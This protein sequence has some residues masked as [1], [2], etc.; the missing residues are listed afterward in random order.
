[1]LL[2]RALNRGYGMSRFR[3]PIQ[4]GLLNSDCLWVMDEVQL[5][6]SGLATTAQLQAFRKALGTASPVHSLW[7]SATL[8][9]DWLNTVDFAPFGATL[10]SFSLSDEDRKCP[11]IQARISCVKRL[12]KAGCTSEKPNEVVELI[13]DNHQ[14]GTRT[15]VVVNTVKRAMEIYQALK[16]KKPKAD[17]SLLHSRFRP[18]DRQ[19]ALEKVLR[20]PGPEG[21]ICVSTQVVEAGVDF[22]AAT[23]ITELAPWASLVQRFGRCNRYGTDKDA[24]VL[25]LDLSLGKKG[26]ALP[27][28]PEELSQ[29]A[30]QLVQLK[31]VCPAKLPT[32]PMKAGYSHV[33]R[34]RDLVDLFDTTPDL[35]GMDIDIS[36]F[37]READDHDCQVFWRSLDGEDAPSETEP[38]PSRDELCSVA[39]S[40]LRSLKDVPMWRWDHLEKRWGRIPNTFSIS[41][42]MVILMDQASGCYSSEF[43]WTGKKTDIPQQIEPPATE[44][45]A[46][47]DDQYLKSDWQTLAEHSDMVVAELEGILTGCPV[48]EAHRAQLDVGS[49]V[50]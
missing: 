24:K 30:E 5:M 19:N 34:K 35:S 37:I 17:L 20:A 23:L 15:L 42:G 31:D 11:G 22:S 28:S 21:S 45:E 7:M 25:W 41:P 13:L 9:R 47:D 16:K 8:Q 36:R 14:K 6:G 48:P 27:Y 44:T 46:I 18:P 29:A 2:S 26:A 4:F 49:Q 38:A 39:V 1:M 3:W 50:A 32:V 43:G 12:E 33:I 10:Q 40:E